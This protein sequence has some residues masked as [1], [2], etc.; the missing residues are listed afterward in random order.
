MNVQ[1]INTL[2]I[3]YRTLIRSKIDYGSI[4]YDFTALQDL[5][6]LE[7]TAYEGMRKASGCFKS[8]PITSLQVIVTEPTLIRSLPNIPA[9]NYITPEQENVYNLKRIHLPLR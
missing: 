1:L 3:I 7:T 9:F 6:A 8:T 5:K 4:V 2:M